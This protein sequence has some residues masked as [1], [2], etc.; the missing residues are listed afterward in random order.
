[1]LLQDILLE[2][3]SVV[4]CVYYLELFSGGIMK[5]I[6]IFVSMILILLTGCDPSYVESSPELYTV[7][8]NNIL[9]AG[10]SRWEYTYVIEEDSYGR[11]MFLYTA[12]PSSNIYLGPIYAVCICQ[13]SDNEYTYYYEDD[14]FFVCVNAEELVNRGTVTRLLENISQNDIDELKL[15]NDWEKE[16]NEEKMTVSRSFKQFNDKEEYKSGSQHY[17]AA[18][19]AVKCPDGYRLWYYIICSDKAGRQLIWIQEKK[20]DGTS[21]NLEDIR[22][23]LVIVGK[24]GE[25]ESDDCILELTTEHLYDYRDIVKEFKAEN[26]W[27]KN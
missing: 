21:T 17:K 5:K 24:N 27:N 15:R 16:L 6:L 9:G 19:N 23:F 2:Q 8:A 7:V 22:N 26:N 4:Q 10:M 25:V 18:L 11:V 1:M 12:T 13:K 14:C 3:N 20:S